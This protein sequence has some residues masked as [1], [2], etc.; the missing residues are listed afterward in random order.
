MCVVPEQTGAGEIFPTKIQPQ[1][2][3]SSRV[4]IALQCINT[5]MAILPHLN[6]AAQRGN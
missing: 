2:S 4:Y 1:K 3:N 5:L 6:L